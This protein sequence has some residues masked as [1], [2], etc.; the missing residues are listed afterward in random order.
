MKTILIT[1]YELNFYINT[2]LTLVK[3]PKS[4]MSVFVELERT[5]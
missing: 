1:F 2:F 3:L 4:T 5:Y